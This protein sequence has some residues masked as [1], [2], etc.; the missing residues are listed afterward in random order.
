MA[1]NHQLLLR[2]FLLASILIWQQTVVWSYIT[3]L[4]RFIIFSL[5]CSKAFQVLR[6]K[7]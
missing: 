1:A 4:K 2:R 5:E 3:L 7:A 6:K